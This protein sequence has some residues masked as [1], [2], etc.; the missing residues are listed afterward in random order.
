MYRYEIKIPKER[1]AVLIGEKG[2]VKKEIEQ[3]TRSRLDIDSEEGDVFISGTDS[4]GLMTVRDVVK[5]I[6]RGFNP[7]IAMRLT[8]QDYS[9]EAI[10]IMDFAKNTKDIVRVRG[11]I[12]G[13]EGKARKKLEQITETSISVYGKTVGIIGLMDKVMLAKQAIESLLKGSPHSKVYAKILRKTKEGSRREMLE[14][15]N[16]ENG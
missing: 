8:K 9:F 10:D 13:R 2:R 7:E 4:V 1:I 11:R 14:V 16:I 15:E 3:A 6:G 12:I 5:S